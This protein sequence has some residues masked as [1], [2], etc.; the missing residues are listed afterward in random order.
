M[1]KGLTAMNY[2][3]YG[4]ELVRLEVGQVSDGLVEILDS[5]QQSN[6]TIFSLIKEK[7]YTY[8]YKRNFLY[9]HFSLYL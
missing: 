3:N 4:G 8:T 6:V 1:S 5:S 7:A 2:G 9:L